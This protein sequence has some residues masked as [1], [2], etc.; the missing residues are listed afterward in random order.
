MTSP[1]PKRKNKKALLKKITS[2]DIYKQQKKAEENKD[3]IEFLK[4]LFRILR[5]YGTQRLL[6]KLHEIDVRGF[7]SIRAEMSEVILFKVCE[8][9]SITREQFNSNRTHKNNIA[10]EARNMFY[11]LCNDHL[12]MTGY[13]IGEYMGINTSYIYRML[14]NI[15]SMNPKIAVHRDFLNRKERLDQAIKTM[16]QEFKEQYSEPDPLRRTKKVEPLKK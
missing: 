3:V 12:N 2:V 13:D 16:K 8:D 6:K 9:Y 1:L 7:D 4:I 14:R 15:K 5:K 10:S 11:L